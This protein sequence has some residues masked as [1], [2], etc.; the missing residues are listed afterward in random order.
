MATQTQ[1]VAYKGRSYR[2]LWTGKTQSPPTSTRPR[3]RGPTGWRAT[4]ALTEFD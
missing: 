4:G 2:L 3:R 1:I